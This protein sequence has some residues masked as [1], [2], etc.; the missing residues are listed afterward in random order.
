MDIFFTGELK[1]PSTHHCPGLG[2][3]AALASAHFGKIQPFC[4]ILSRARNEVSKRL[5]L[6][7]AAKDDDNHADGPVARSYIPSITAL[8]YGGERG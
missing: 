4:V 5:S 1:K 8:R 6:P 7:G 2:S 3:W